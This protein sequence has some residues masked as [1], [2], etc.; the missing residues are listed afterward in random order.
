MQSLLNGP[1]GLAPDGN[2]GFFLSDT[3]NAGTR[4]SFDRLILVPHCYG[5]ALQPSGA[6]SLMAPSCSL[7][8]ATASGRRATGALVRMV[9][10]WVNLLP[11]TKPC[12]A[13]SRCPYSQQGSRCS[14]S[15][16]P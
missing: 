13:A 11:P 2:G 8:E 9:I 15:P 5:P 4:V 10:T 7:L 1:R 3:T 6:C 14:V 16:N 12:F